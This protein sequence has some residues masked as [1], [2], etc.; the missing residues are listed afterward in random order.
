MTDHKPLNE[1]GIDAVSRR[2][3][4][5]IVALHKS[6]FVVEYI[7]GV[8]IVVADVLSRLV[9]SDDKDEKRDIKSNGNDEEAGVIEDNAVSENEWRAATDTDGDL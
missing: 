7:P 1:I 6:D 8:K 5:W 9:S 4:K 2:I 3:T